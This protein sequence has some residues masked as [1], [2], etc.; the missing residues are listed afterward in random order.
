WGKT[1]RAIRSMLRRVSQYHASW[2]PHIR[3]RRRSQRPLPATPPLVA[4]PALVSECAGAL[5]LSV[6]PYSCNVGKCKLILIFTYWPLLSTLPVRAR[7]GDPCVFLLSESLRFSFR[8]RKRDA[9]TRVPLYSL[10]LHKVAKPLWGRLV[11][12]MFLLIAAFGQFGRNGSQC[13]E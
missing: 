13:S 12:R 4:L 8:T 10:P 5:V 3:L 1:G 9:R 11:T 2:P 6:T 7:F